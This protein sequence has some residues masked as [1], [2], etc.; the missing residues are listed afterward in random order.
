MM[1]FN[2]PE[3]WGAVA[4]FFH[5]TMAL[6]ILFMLGLGLYMTSLELGPRVFALFALH[7]SLG[8]VVLALAVLRIGWKS[9]NIRPQDLPTHKL[10]ERRLAHVTHGLL[11]FAMIAMPLSGWMM[12]SAKNFHV[13]VFNRFTLPDLVAPNKD[14]AEALETFHDTMAYGL[15]GLLALHAAGAIKHHVIDKDSTLRRMLPLTCFKGDIL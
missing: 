14:L 11:Y 6:L 4:K 9:F 7:K 15:I 3:R 2:S 13:S 1:L 12:S 5:W 10:W 8:M